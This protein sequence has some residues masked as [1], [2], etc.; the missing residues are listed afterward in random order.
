[1]GRDD[2]LAQLSGSDDFLARIESAEGLARHVGDAAVRD[3]LV[4]ALRRPGFYAAKRA[5]AIAI[6]RVGGDA[7]RDALIAALGDKDLRARRGIVRALGEFRADVTA[8]AALRSAFKKEKSYFVRGETLGALARIAAP[9]TF[10]FLAKAMETDSFR[11]VIRAT[12][13][14]G[15]AE[16]EEERGIDVV[17]PWVRPG[18][19]RWTRDYAMRAL[20]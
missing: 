19:S 10:E 7:S 13:L 4:A 5:L 18:Q 9:Q 16:L 8:A 12:A 3:A 17:L 14:R 2:L 1:P 15:I 6:A 20:A 11:D